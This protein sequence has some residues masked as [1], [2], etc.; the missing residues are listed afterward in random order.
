MT[1]VP[2]KHL[3][4]S[5]RIMRGFWRL[6]LAVGVIFGVIGIAFLG[7]AAWFH[8]DHYLGVGSISLIIAVGG[9]ASSI[10]IGWI[11][12]GFFN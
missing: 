1:H 9:F 11:V 3:S 7:S 6:G 5:K 4:T 2:P 10:G 12:S 8:S